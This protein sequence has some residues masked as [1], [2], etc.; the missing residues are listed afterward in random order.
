MRTPIVVPTLVLLAA[1]SSAVRP[2]TVADPNSAEQSAQPVEEDPDAY[3]IYSV[4][5]Q[6]EGPPVKSWNIRNETDR[7]WLPMCVTPPPEQEAIYRPVIE[8]FETRNQHKLLL[9][10]HFDLPAYQLVSREDTILPV[11]EVSAVGFNREHTR[12]LVY[13][14]HHCGNLCGGGTYHLMAKKNGKW[15]PDREFRGAPMCMWAS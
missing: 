11:F 15:E 10:R 1:L 5:L 8:Q 9:A 7:G 13:V 6:A 2:A 4:L 14:A 12:A 3:S